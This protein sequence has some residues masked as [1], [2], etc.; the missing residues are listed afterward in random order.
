MILHGLSSSVISTW[1]HYFMV[2]FL[3]SH[4]SANLCCQCV[5]FHEISLNFSDSFQ[6]Y[7]T[8]PLK[9]SGVFFVLFFN[10]QVL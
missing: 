5:V 3:S 2:E 4:I 1:I 7:T 8:E 9:E 6:K 10:N